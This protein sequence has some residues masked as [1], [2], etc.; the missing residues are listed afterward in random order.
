MLS[1]IFKDMGETRFLKNCTFLMA[2]LTLLSSF[3]L[4]HVMASVYTVGD[5]EEWSSQT[6]YASWA[7]RYNFSQGDV[8]VF[9]YV[10]GQHN[11]Y[12]V[13]EDT[14]RSCDASSGVLAK[15]ES[16]EDQVALSEVKR[17]WFICNIAGHCLGGMRFGIE[18]KDGNSVTNSTD[19]AFNPPIEPTPS[20]NS[21]T[22]YYVSERW[23]V[24]ENFIPLGLLL[25]LNYYF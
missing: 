7:E 19:V 16:G 9:K 8:L 11:V 24:I 22:C 2:I 13:T 17:H 20:H 12:E 6:N 25:L 21:C 18:V 4:N 1:Y 10:K 15:Y 23:R 5:Q 3:L 14:F